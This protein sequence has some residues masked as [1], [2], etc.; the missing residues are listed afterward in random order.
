MKK[1]SLFIVLLF[2]IANNLVEVKISNIYV[3]RKLLCPELQKANISLHFPYPVKNQVKTVTNHYFVAPVA[4]RRSA[5][6]RGCDII[7]ITYP[8]LPNIES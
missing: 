7:G 2:I 6:G 4:T 1:I 8:E 5:N 3:N